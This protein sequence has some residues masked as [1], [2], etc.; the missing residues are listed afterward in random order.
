[1]SAYMKPGIR[2]WSYYLWYEPKIRSLL[3]LLHAKGFQTLASCQGHQPRESENYKRPFFIT[4]YLP[5]PEKRDEL[6]RLYESLVLGLEDKI[7]QERLGGLRFSE[8]PSR[9][10]KLYVRIEVTNPPWTEPEYEALRHTFTEVARKKVEDPN[11]E[12]VI[13]EI[14]G[15]IQHKIETDPYT[16]SIIRYAWST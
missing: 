10:G 1:M 11:I 16:K 14:E 5:T 9:S 3:V 8:K 15:K 13:E 7:P 2:K 4:T 6:R 12:G